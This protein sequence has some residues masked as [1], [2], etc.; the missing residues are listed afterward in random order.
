M[1]SNI[2]KGIFFSAVVLS[3]LKLFSKQSC[4]QMFCHPSFVVA[5]IE[6]KRNR[7]S[8]VL[9]G[10]RIFGMVKGVQASASGYQGP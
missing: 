10:P 9:K 5:F 4:K 7:G 8:L 2:L 3:E 1:S 6:H